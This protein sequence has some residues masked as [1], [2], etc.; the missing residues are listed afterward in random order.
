VGRVGRARAAARWPARWPRS[1]RAVSIAARWVEDLASS[2]AG[3]RAQLA[4][5]CVDAAARRYDELVGFLMQK[6]LRH[7]P[8]LRRLSC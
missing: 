7:P 4:R 5:L 6:R 1:P 3:L 2:D 8:A